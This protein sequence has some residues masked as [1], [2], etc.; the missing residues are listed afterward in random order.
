MENA[1]LLDRSGID[2]TQKV[3]EEWKPTDDD[4]AMRNENR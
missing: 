3:R 2:F 4:H 1:T